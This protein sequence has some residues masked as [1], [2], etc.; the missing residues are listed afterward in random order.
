MNK[1]EIGSMTAKGGFAN[2]KSICKK[3]NSWN[4]DKEAQIW[5]SIMGYNIERIDSV[6]AV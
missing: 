6:K 2:E 5:L 3:F 4:K 1:K